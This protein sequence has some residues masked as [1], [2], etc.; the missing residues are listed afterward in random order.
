[1]SPLLFAHRPRT[2]AAHVIRDI[3]STPSNSVSS[4]VSTLVNKMPPKKKK[5]K[6]DNMTEEEKRVFLEQKLLAEEEERKKKEEML[7]QFLRDKLAK[8]EKASKFNLIKIQNQWR[9]IMRKA[10]AQELRRE[11]DILS[12]T[13]ERIVDRKDA[14]I[15]SLKTDLDE[16]DEQYQRALCSHLE[17]LDN[18]T[19]LQKSHISSLEKE[20]QSSLQSLREE[21][22]S[23]RHSLVEKHKV[24]TG[25]IMDI[26]FAMEQEFKK[27]EED[28]LQ[29]FQSIR[30]EIKNKNIEEKHALRVQLETQMEELWKQINDS[31]KQYRETTEERK[32][33][34]ER[35]K[36]QDELGAREIAQ[37]MRKLQRIQD[38]IAQV[39]ARLSSN[40]RDS[41]ERNKALRSEKEEILGHFQQLKGQMN[42]FREAERSRLTQLTIY[43]NEAIK[44]LRRKVAKAERILKLSEMCRK[45][46]TEEEKVMPFYP[47]SLSQEEE[48]EVAAAIAEPASQS[49]AQ[50]ASEYTS[51]EN[52]W[53]RYNKVLLDKLAL[54]KEK[55][56]LLEENQKLRLVLKQYL[57][58]ISVN[59]EVLQ[60]ANPLFVVNQRTNALLRVPVSDPRVH[61]KRPAQCIVEAAHVVKNTLY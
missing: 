36:Q 41:D 43:S 32:Q 48:E 55:K 44:E 57:D 20:F 45:L 22:D 47:S 40:A 12:Q 26:M 23:E 14:V 58:G 4:C 38:Q 8:E 54:A 29:D 49:L 9:T 42:R 7:S 27:H 50:A 28:A 21:F 46:E 53:K 25:D 2:S 37:Q 24:G 52:F 61:M 11:I 56:T 1:M 6:M 31:L 17:Q 51:L 18:L 35:L 19:E 39:R 13:F 33:T 59:D 34:F 5:N 60:Q 15:K 30:D 16:A 10:K 3:T